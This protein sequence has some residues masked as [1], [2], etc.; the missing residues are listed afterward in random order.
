[1][2]NGLPSEATLQTAYNVGKRALGCNFTKI[3]VKEGIDYP[4]KMYEKAKKKE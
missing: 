2:G 1:M 4:S 3:L